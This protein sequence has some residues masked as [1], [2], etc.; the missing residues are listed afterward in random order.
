MM[1]TVAISGRTSS[2]R[3]SRNPTRTT[4][5]VAASVGICHCR[6]STK[7]VAM[8]V[9]PGTTLTTALAA[10]SDATAR[11][12]LR[13]G[14]STRLGTALATYAITVTTTSTASCVGDN[15]DNAARTAS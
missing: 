15:A 3:G 10:R 12:Q 13:A 4:A 2:D 1:P 14:S 6:Y 11:R 5:A 7:R 9:G 8:S